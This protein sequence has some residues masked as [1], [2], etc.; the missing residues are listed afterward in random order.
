MRYSILLLGLLFG[1]S[2]LCFDYGIGL[3]TDK[4]KIKDGTV[5]N[6]RIEHPAGLNLY[7]FGPGGLANLSFD[8]FLTPK[9]ALEIG[10]GLRNEEGDIGYFLGG[11]YHLFGGSFLNLTPYAGVYTAFHYTGEDVRNH[12]LYV[13]FGLHKIKKSGISWSVELAYEASIYE[14]NHF[15]GGFRLGYRF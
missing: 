10:G 11:R 1:G 5:L 14:D 13:P 7:G 9:V 2:A 15:S 6:R 4:K 8:Y 3:D 12:S